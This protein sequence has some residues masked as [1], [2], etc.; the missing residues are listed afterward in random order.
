MNEARPAH[1]FSLPS[2][3]DLCVGKALLSAILSALLV[4]A[5]L[6]GMAIGARASDGDACK[7]ARLV[8]D[9]PLDGAT[10]DQC[11]AALD[12]AEE[13]KWQLWLDV[14]SAL[15]LKNDTERAATMLSRFVAQADS[16]GARI[17]EH[18][19]AVRED[20]RAKV[21]KL[22]E[23]LLKDKGRV[24]IITT[25]EGAEVTF[26]GSN[27]AGPAD[28][29]P[30]TRYLAPG[31]HVARIIAPGSGEARE[32]TFPVGVGQHVE[33]KVGLEASGESTVAVD[34]QLVG[35]KASPEVAVSEPV[36]PPNPIEA[37]PEVGEEPLGGEATGL[38]T[39]LGT[40]GITLGGA[41][42]AVGIVFAL[43]GAG[44]D[45]EASCSGEICNIDAPL[46]ALVRAD[47]DTAWGRA[48]GAF[49]VGG[50]LLAGGIVAVVLDPDR[51]ASA[52]SGAFKPRVTPWLSPDG[53]GLSGTVSF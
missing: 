21:K 50:A 5:M 1:K 45:D 2:R 8:L 13:E 28:K 40:A 42:V 19:A 48:T 38:W 34:G 23:G 46:R 7:K 52:G 10:E 33:V 12:A 20:V 31:T 47:S 18:W 43:Q 14:A 24:V 30:V 25:P 4:A 9:E 29:T 37:S 16:R 51:A 15:E 36:G 49:I 41:A 11:L 35:R 26:V 32:V 22:E 3:L 6:G 53:A 27:R 39:R 44:L 17:S